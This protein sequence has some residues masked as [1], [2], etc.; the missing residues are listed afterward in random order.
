MILLAAK[1]KA[2]TAQADDASH[3]ADSE[4]CILQMRTLLDV[5]LDEAGIAFA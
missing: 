1:D 3:D 2:N 5:R 4:P